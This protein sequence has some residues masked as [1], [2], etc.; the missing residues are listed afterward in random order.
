MCGIVGKVNKKNEKINKS[1]IYNMLS[2]IKHRG[3]DGEGI[4]INNNIGLGHNLL[5]IQ[6]LSDDAIQPY[7][8]KNYVL[9]YNGEIYNFLELKK[10]LIENSYSF[11]TSTDTEV[12][13]KYIDYKGLKETLNRIE[14]CFAIAIYNEK[15][16][17]TYIIRDRFGIKPLYYYNDNDNMIWA[18]EIKSILQNKNV[19]RKFDY[20]TIAISLNCRLWMDPQKTF[21]KEINMLEPGTFIKID[22]FGNVNKIRYY[23]IPKKY[24][25]KNIEDII[26]K[27]SIELDDSIR[28]KLI[29]K[30]PLAAFLS[31]GLDSSIVC[32]ILNDN[33]TDK[34]STYTI[35][36]NNDNDLDVN[37]AKILSDK[38][39]FRQHNILINE[40]MYNIENI[41]KVI[42]YVEEILIDKVYIPM[43]FNYKAA[44]DDGY[45]VVVSGQGADEPWLGYI[46]TW[47]IFKYLDKNITEEK[48]IDNYYIYNMIFKDKLNE[49]FKKTMKPA[50]KNYLTNNLKINKVDIL[51]SYSDLSIKTILHDLLVQEDKLAMANSIESRVPFVDNHRLMEL[52][53]NVESK[54]KIL[55]GRE[56]YIIRRF[57]DNKINREILTRKKYPFPEPPSI[58]NEHIKRICLENWDRIKKSKILNKIIDI[59]KLESI[60]NFTSIEQWWLLM[61]WRFEEVF[62]MEV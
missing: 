29:S 22:K 36:Y 32:K 49:N 56:K 4:Y 28:K 44:K 39:N 41:N 35:K 46:F 21:F 58:Y 11:E 42:Y 6:D 20:E 27:F 53:Y 23:K 12:L 9:T 25:Y 26:N 60:D 59:K 61:Y 34:L 40:D 55:D 50:M 2:V 19:K 52:S 31:G 57:A 37:H 3:P 18:S 14:G 48:L 45:T 33:M 10:E 38:E 30:V 43:Y 47:K 15:K 13:I 1:E 16:K 5:K 17:D 54:I 24:K 62:E 51:N 7:K 8:Y